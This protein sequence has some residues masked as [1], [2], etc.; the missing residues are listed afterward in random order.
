MNQRK[1]V[2]NRLI[3]EIEQLPTLPIVSQR[4]M[5]VIDDENVTF[6]EIVDIVEKDQALALKL[7]K[8]ANSS[9]Y[10]SL[11]KVSSLEHA[12]IKLG[13]REVKSIVLGFSV[14]S[15]FPDTKNGA[16][17]RKRFWEH[18]VVVSQVAKLL[19]THFRVGNDDSLFL[20]GLVH[21]MGKVVLDQYFHEEFLRIIDHV[22]KNGSTFSQAEKDVLG[23]THY[24]IAAKI[25]KQWH[26]PKNVTFQVLY[27]HAPWHDHPFQANSII[28]YLANIL[29]KLA[30]YSCHPDEKKIDIEQ[31]VQ[32]S[33]M[34]FLVK[35]GFELDE[36]ILRNLITKIQEFIADESENV[37]RLFS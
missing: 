31:F 6:K 3:R 1:E 15:F 23:T 33:E 2:L 27:H 12:M 26:F 25:L 11:S 8:I 14:Q 29:S 36:G 28:I 17:D 30:G 34:E 21:D 32:S 22:S 4:I 37:M 18:A 35:N 9:F 24:Q 7:L 13:T 16:F 10:G 19:G 5:Q 20:A